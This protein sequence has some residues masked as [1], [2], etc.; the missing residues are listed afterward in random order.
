MEPSYN[1]E[2]IVKT[3]TYVSQDFQPPDGTSGNVTGKQVWQEQKD[4]TGGGGCMV[5][6]NGKNSMVISVKNLLRGG[7]P[8]LILSV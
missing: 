4:G 5:H 6:P 1:F 8:L 2:L 7:G 3:M